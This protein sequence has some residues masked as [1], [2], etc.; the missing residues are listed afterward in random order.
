MVKV[1]IT[2]MP[3]RKSQVINILR[4]FIRKIFQNKLNRLK[5][6]INEDEEGGEEIRKMMALAK[7]GVLPKMMKTLLMMILM[8]II[9]YLKILQ[10]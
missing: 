3:L 8:Q 5:E 9:Q 1:S 2:K 7:E 4:Q 6:K 10:A